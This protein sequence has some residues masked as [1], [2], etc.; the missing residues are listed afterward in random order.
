MLLWHC[1][2]GA[3]ALCDAS[4]CGGN[5]VPPPG[6]AGL[7]ARGAPMYAVMLLWST[8]IMITVESLAT[9]PRGELHLGAR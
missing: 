5:L 7:P 4:D 1:V 6:T 3:V 2:N 8:E 9:A